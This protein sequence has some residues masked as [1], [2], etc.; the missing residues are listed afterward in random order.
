MSDNPFTECSKA[1]Y[2]NEMHT[3]ALIF[4]SALEPSDVS[5][6]CRIEYKFRSTWQVLRFEKTKGSLFDFL[7]GSYFQE[8]T[9]DSTYAMN[10][11]QFET[12]RRL[13]NEYLDT[14]I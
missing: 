6:G 11:D 4:Q 3:L 9:N 2:F 10:R 12:L 14:H 13:A 7:H 8:Y 5:M 1:G